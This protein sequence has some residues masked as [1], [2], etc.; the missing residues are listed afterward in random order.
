M[1]SAAPRRDR[2]GVGILLGIGRKDHGDDLGFVQEPFG[3]QRADRTIDQAAGENFFFR[4]TPLAFD[5]TARNLAGGVSVLA[6]VD[7]ERKKTRL[8]VSD[9]RPCK[10]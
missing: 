1:A 2:Q 6:V 9:R 7:G 3:E 4:G 10:R 8:P 5:K